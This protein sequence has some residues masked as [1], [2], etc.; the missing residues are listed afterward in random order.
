MLGEVGDLRI[1]VM[2]IFPG[3]PRGKT[4]FKGK[5]KINVSQKSNKKFAE[6]IIIQQIRKMIN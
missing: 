3:V 5:N 2:K 1:Q 4:Y 6:P